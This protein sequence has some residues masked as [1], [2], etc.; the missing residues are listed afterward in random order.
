MDVTTLALLGAGGGLLRGVV[1][2]YA[3]FTS[4]RVDRLTH[5][6]LVAAGATQEN[7]PR[8]SA[9]F[10]PSVDVA[11]ALVHCL[12]GSVTAAVLGETGQINGEYA[13][14]VVGMSAPMLLTQL[15]RIQTVNEAVTGNRP[16]VEAEP[17]PSAAGT[18]SPVGMP[19][20]T[21][22]P[23]GM[24][25]ATATVEAGTVEPP[26]ATTPV[27]PP[28][29]ARPAPEPAAPPTDPARPAPRPVPVQ[30]P[31]AAASP[32]AAADGP[33]PGLDGRGTPRWGQSPAAREE[34]L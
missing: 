11:A 16:S 32:P 4:W 30:R 17:T 10:D 20:A 14:V 33:G 7:G 15:S 26:A 24:P 23:V 3:R 6:Q 2:L 1:D 18:T 31:S 25:D 8:F 22:T 34:G 28:A 27:E 19:D 21:A 29:R 9:Y 5:R 12:L 13:A